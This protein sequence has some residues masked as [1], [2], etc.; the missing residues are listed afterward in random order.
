MEF[1]IW[2]EAANIIV[3]YSSEIEGDEITLWST[4]INE[5]DI[6]QYYIFIVYT[7]DE[8][9]IE[10]EP[11]LLW[12]RIS[13][14]SSDT[15]EL[16]SKLDPTW[17]INTISPKF[18][19]RVFEQ[20]RGEVS[21]THAYFDEETLPSIEETI[22]WEGIVASG[23]HSF[24]LFSF[25]GINTNNTIGGF[26]I[27]TGTYEIATIYG[28]GQSRE[29]YLITSNV[30]QDDCLTIIAEDYN[31]STGQ[32]SGIYDAWIQNNVI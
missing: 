32:I 21:E 2:D 3:R 7:W 19:V 5:L 8:E 1:K 22:R 29:D 16:T 14:K 23:S 11:D 18:K 12:K 31:S 28:P 17:N 20:D 13:A 15:I 25:Y 27:Y 10:K 9:L 30:S 6:D 26:Q 24:Y 4:I